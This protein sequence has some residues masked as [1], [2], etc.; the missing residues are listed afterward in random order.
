MA[1]KFDALSPTTFRS[2]WDDGT[3]SPGD[4]PRGLAVELQKRFAS[5]E[6]SP[7]SLKAELAKLHGRGEL[8]DEAYQKRFDAWTMATTGEG[9]ENA[10]ESAFHKIIRLSCALGKAFI[11]S[12][13]RGG[14][15]YRMCNDLQNCQCW[16]WC[17]CPCL[18]NFLR[19]HGKV[20]LIDSEDD[21][22]DEHHEAHHVKKGSTRSSGRMPSDT[23][24][25]SEEEESESEEDESE[26]E[27]SSSEGEALRKS[28]TS[29]D[30]GKSQ[31][32][33]T[34]KGKK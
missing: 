33:A 14:R 32:K 5:G 12:F 27:Q 34:A 23:E 25:D 9:L 15:G 4:S 13:K 1:V 16:L 11:G 31:T 8:N 2:K 18:M 10:H 21:S 6:C 26:S 30:S 28:A 17:L 19:R 24:E 7:R 29:H 22:P 20:P 3:L